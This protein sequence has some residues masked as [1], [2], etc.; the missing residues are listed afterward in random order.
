MTLILTKASS[1]YVLQTSDRRITAGAEIADKQAN[2]GMVYACQNAIVTVAYTGM[3]VLDE[4]PTDQWLAETIIGTRFD[5]DRK[6]PAFPGSISPP[7]ETIGQTLTRISEALR[8]AVANVRPIWRANWK[9]MHFDIVAA[10]WQWNSRGRHRPIIAWISKPNGRT[11]VEK[12]CRNRLWHYPRQGKRPFTV[13]AAPSVNFYHRDREQLLSKLQDRSLEE[14]ESALVDEMREVSVAIPE[15]GRDVLSVTLLPPTIAAGYVFDRVEG[16]RRRP[17]RSSF[18][19]NLAA[20][21]AIAPWLIGPGTVRPPTELSRTTDIQLGSYTLRLAA[22][23]SSQRVF[24]RWTTE[25]KTLAIQ[26]LESCLRGPRRCH[27]GG[28]SGSSATRKLSPQ[29]DDGGMW[30]RAV[31]YPPLRP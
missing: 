1:D 24:C 17:I 21:V 20:D 11:D 15:V 25:A 4:V 14:C 5:R 9:A 30:Q 18:L 29:N 16:A 19:P 26:H 31:D 7:S 13:V 27:F 8:D 3:S 23:D 2:K 12:G 10:G 6:V 28:T 22:P